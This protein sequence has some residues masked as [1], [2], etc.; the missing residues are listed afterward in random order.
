V[1]FKESAASDYLK[2]HVIHS[3]LAMGNFRDGG[4]IIVGVSQRGDQ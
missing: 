1:D 2:W 4:V 3:V